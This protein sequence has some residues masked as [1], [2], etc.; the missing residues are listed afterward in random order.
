MDLVGRTL[1]WLLEPPARVRV[2]APAH[3]Q[4]V[5]AGDVLQSFI[6]SQNKLLE[7]VSAASGLALDRIMVASPVDSRVR[8]NVWSAFQ[9]AEA[10]QRRH[11]WQAER[12]AGLS[13]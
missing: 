4:P 10:H 11:L 6:E 8:Y 12:A 2:K 9:V 1:K 7:I 3:L 13:E 5:A